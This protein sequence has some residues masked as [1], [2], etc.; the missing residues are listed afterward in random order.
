MP[1]LARPKAQVA[2]RTARTCPRSAWPMFTAVWA[3]P[4][5]HTRAQ[6]ID[7]FQR[8]LQ[9]KLDEKMQK[10]EDYALNNIFHIPADIVVPDS[11]EA[12]DNPHAQ[13]EALDA[14]MIALAA[15]VEQAVATRR[16]LALQLRQ[17]RAQMDAYQVYAPALAPL[18]GIAPHAQDTHAADIR[19]NGAL[20]KL[21]RNVQ[22]LDQIREKILK[23]LATSALDNCATGGCSSA[24]RC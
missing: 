7:L 6:G 12:S 20:H 11:S 23:R 21:E 19:M 16:A 15:R 24:E 13:P 3:T 10:L 22:V 5:S 18:V 8:R 9:R 1:P 2:S 17:A 14:E 4:C